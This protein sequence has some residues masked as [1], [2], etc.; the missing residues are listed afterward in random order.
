[1]LPLEIHDHKLAWRNKTPYTY[2]THSDVRSAVQDWCKFNVKKH[3]WHLTT[4][5]EA[6]TDFLEFETKDDYES[7]R[8]W[9]KELW[10]A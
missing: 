6:Y 3:Q 9:Y 1:M 2:H 7:F 8:I 10:G 5:I 4:Y